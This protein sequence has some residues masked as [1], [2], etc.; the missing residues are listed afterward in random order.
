MK[1]ISERLCLYSGECCFQLHYHN[2][3]CLLKGRFCWQLDWK[4]CKFK[5]PLPFPRDRTFPNFILGGISRNDGKANLL[6]WAL[7]GFGT[8]LLRV[9]AGYRHHG[10][11]APIHTT[12]FLIARICQGKDVQSAYLGCLGLVYSKGVSENQY[13]TLVWNSTGIQLG[14]HLYY[15]TM[16]LPW[17]K[18]NFVCSI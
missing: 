1:H 7:S 18:A 13:L 12:L 10:P 4:I 14:I 2:S 11:L 5:N 8:V 17:V 6:P 9:L 16:D 3:Y 15:K